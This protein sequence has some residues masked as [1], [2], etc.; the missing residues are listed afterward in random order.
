MPLA[1]LADENVEMN[2]AQSLRDLGHQ[3]V[4]VAESTPGS[5]DEILLLGA[6]RQGHLL[7]TNDKDF[8]EL[9]FRQRQSSAGV[10]LVRLPGMSPVAKANI[11]AN[12]VTHYGDRLLGS[13]LV[14]GERTMRIRRLPDK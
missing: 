14:I 2:I 4:H 1:F 9:V 5:E 6:L 12:A 11:V 7:I 10:I 8:G 13:F 3:V